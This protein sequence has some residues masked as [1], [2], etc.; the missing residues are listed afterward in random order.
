MGL[1]FHAVAAV[2]GDSGRAVGRSYPDGRTNVWAM[3][4]GDRHGASSP[5]ISGMLNGVLAFDSSNAR[6]VGDGST[7]F[8]W[9]LEHWNGSVWPSGSS[10]RRYLDAG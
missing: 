5:L 2:E 9:L 8:R 1:S 4:S 10:P 6:A 3:A 7:Q